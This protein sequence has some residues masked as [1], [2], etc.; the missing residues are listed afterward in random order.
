MSTTNGTPATAPDARRLVKTSTPG[1][2]RKQRRDG[3]AGSYVVIYRAAGKQRKETARTLA[4]ARA[5]RSARHAERDRASWPPCR[6]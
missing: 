4:E 3:S 1:I 5:I 6:R 2:Y